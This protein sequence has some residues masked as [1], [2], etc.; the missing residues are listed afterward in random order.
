[1]RVDM[2]IEEKQIRIMVIDNGSG[3]PFHGRYDLATLMTREMGPVSLGVLTRED[4]FVG[5]LIIDSSTSG[6]SLEI[7]LPLEQSEWNLP[8]VNGQKSLSSVFQENTAQKG[9]QDDN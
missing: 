8:S 2:S 9:E 7:T 1:M 5:G 6:S 4:H 3:F